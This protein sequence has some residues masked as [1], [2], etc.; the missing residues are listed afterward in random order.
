MRPAVIK[1][2]GEE[3]LDSFSGLELVLNYHST[4]L[5]DVSY[6]RHSVTATQMG[7]I[8]NLAK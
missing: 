6:T 7:Q 2:W 3:I 5:S 8:P 4:A 1:Q